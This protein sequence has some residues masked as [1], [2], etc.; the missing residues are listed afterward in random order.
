MW[1]CMRIAGRIL[2]FPGVLATLKNG[3]HFVF[4]L[5]TACRVFIKLLRPLVKRWRSKGLRC[6]V[7]ID[8]GIFAARSQDQCVE[9]TKMILDDLALAWFILNIPKSKLTPQQVGQILV[10]EVLSVSPSS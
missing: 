6:I 4:F 8:D 1:T 2:A 3:I 5:S 9:G 7:Y 10:R